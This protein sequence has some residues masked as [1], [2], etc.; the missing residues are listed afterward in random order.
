MLKQSLES[1]HGTHHQ[2]VFTLALPLVAAQQLQLSRA[3]TAVVPRDNLPGQNRYIGQ[4]KIDSLARQRVNGMC[5][6][7]HQSNTRLHVIDCMALAERKSKTPGASQHCAQSPF[8]GPLQLGAKTFVIQ[9]HH[10]LYQM[11]LQG[12]HERTKILSLLSRQRQ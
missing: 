9:G 6:I 4:A 12:P 7:G 2:Q 3:G 8:A 5:R 10:V 11:L 1:I